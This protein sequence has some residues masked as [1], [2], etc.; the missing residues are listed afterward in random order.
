MIW[1]GSKS[2]YLAAFLFLSF[3]SHAEELIR[4][5]FV[6]GVTL[7]HAVAASSIVAKIQITSLSPVLDESLEETPACGFLYN[8]K[9][10]KS[11][12]GGSD[13]FNFFMPSRVAS[14]SPGKNYLAFVK[15]RTRDEATHIILSLNDAM[16]QSE[17][18]SA[19]CRFR[20]GF[21]V[22]ADSPLVIP[23]DIDAEKEFGGQ[24]LALPP[25]IGLFLC[26]YNVEDSVKDDNFSR[27]TKSGKSVSSW[28]EM[29]RLINKSNRWFD[30]FRK[31]SLDSCIE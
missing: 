2:L 31:N 26:K 23:F 4:L 6:S 29:E 17:S 11:F 9:V 12:K 28:V 18:Y 14:F 7:K 1:V 27:K 24:W 3:N 13:S 30:V 20:S 21:Y 5:H 19:R 25:G 15:Y 10:I 16:S 8:A 22:S